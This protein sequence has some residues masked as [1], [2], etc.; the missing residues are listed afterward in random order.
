MARVL[1][2]QS[3]VILLWSGGV[4]TLSLFP[5]LQNGSFIRIKNI[6]TC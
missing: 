4:T 2:P 1:T 5:H 3:F 6:D